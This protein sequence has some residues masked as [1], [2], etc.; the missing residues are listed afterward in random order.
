ML[1][2]AMIV[3]LGVL[4]VAFFGTLLGCEETTAS[5]SADPHLGGESAGGAQA[6]AGVARPRAP[7][8]LR[9]PRLEGGELLRG[10]APAAGL[11]LPGLVRRSGA[12]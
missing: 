5:S 4:G 7:R 2:R 10:R 1:R 12:S 6:V 9:C 3:T 11:Q 8:W